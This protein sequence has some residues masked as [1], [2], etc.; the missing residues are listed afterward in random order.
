MEARNLSAEQKEA[1]Q[2]LGYI[3][4]Q[5]RQLHK[6]TV[7]YAALLRLY[8]EDYHSLQALCYLHLEMGRPDLALELANRCQ[9]L[10]NM[11]GRSTESSVFLLKSRAL[12]N[13]DRKTEARECMST[14]LRP[15]A[16]RKAP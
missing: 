6:A 16:E 14:F 1:L 4:L 9:S 11:A 3:F 12:W 5:Y 8:P 15:R 7:V 2:L 10:D 13:L